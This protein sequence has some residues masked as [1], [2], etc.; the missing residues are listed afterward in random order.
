MAPG[1]SD[2]EFDTP[3]A[4]EIET[5]LGALADAIRTVCPSGASV[6]FRFDRRLHVDIDVRTVEQA[7]AVERALPNLTQANFNAIRRAKSPSPFLQRITAEVV[8]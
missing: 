1:P 6:S 8:A 3:P 5:A 2:A 7:T 4:G